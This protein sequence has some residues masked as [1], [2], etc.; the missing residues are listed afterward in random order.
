MEIKV[1][2]PE[3]KKP[4]WRKVDGNLALV[5]VDEEPEYSF[6]SIKTFAD[7]CAKLGINADAF[8]VSNGVDQQAQR[9]AQA[10]YKL[11]IVQKAINKGVSCDKNGQT[12]N[13]YWILYT[14]DEM[15]RMSGEEKLSKGVKHILSCT[16]ADLSK[17]SGV[18]NLF[19]PNRDA[20]PI[21]NMSFPFCFN[22]EEA[23]LYAAKQFESLFFD[24]YGIKVKYKLEANMVN[25]G[26]I[27]HASDDSLV[28]I[29]HIGAEGEV[30]YKAYADNARGKLQHEPYT[31]FYGYITDCYPATEKQKRWLRKWIK[32]HE[33]KE[34]KV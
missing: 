18:G 6:E 19:V 22:S 33:K 23:A 11:L 15:N 3:G 30:Y 32:K 24:Y 31:H 13:P 14:M 8:N 25:R 34:E 20:E 12:Y 27:V 17:Y 21:L 2:I 1:E 5:L 10:L 7:A 4:E 29:H 28:L 9:Q 16:C 26:D